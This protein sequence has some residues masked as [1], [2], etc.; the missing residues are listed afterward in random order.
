M[1]ILLAFP[2]LLLEIYQNTS[3]MQIKDAKEIIAQ[4]AINGRVSVSLNHY[5][6]RNDTVFFQLPT[7]LGS[8]PEIRK[9]TYTDSNEKQR[10]IYR[11]RQTSAQKPTIDITVLR[12]EN[13]SARIV[14]GIPIEGVVGRFKLVKK[15]HWTVVAA[16]VYQI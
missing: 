1:K 9:I 7:V 6:N 10:T 5:Y 3:L 4:V 16:E 11:V 12:V 15:G 14:L 13:D 8:Q 2:L